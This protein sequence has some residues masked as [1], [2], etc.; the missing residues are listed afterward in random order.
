MRTAL[1]EK[2]SI[3]IDADFLRRVYHGPDPER[4]AKFVGHA[5]TSPDFFVYAEQ[6]DVL[7]VCELRRCAFGYDRLMYGHHLHGDL[8]LLSLSLAAA[9]RFGCEAYWYPLEEDNP[10]HEQLAHVLTQ[11]Y[12]FSPHHLVLER[13]LP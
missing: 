12:R 7:G 4:F 8:R 11:R 10:R 9:R 5:A 1:S 2:N 6:P 13:R 3:T